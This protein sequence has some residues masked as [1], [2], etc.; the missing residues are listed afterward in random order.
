MKT[1]VTFLQFALFFKDIV[2]RPDRD[3]G[4]LNSEMLNIFDAMPQVIPVP[5]EL[6]PNIPVMLLRSEKNIY[7]CSISRSRI[8]FIVNRIDGIDGEKSNADILK[9]FNVKVAG[10]IKLILK[11]Q[12]VIRFGMVARYFQQ[13]NSAVKTLRNK[14]FTSIVGEA[15]E[16][17]L[18]YNKQSEAYGY[19]INDVLEISATEAVTDGKVE[20]G[21]LIQ[22]DINNHQI[23]GKKIGF[24]TLL[25][26]SEKYAP[27]ITEGEIEGL[28]K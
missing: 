6:S 25:K 20:K 10:I 26:I 19:Q 9:D 14:F 28:L 4:N 22:R 27:R 2:E 17:S 8:D 15:E 24:D 21:I 23:H 16:L 12:E 5:K 11:K 7:T 1:R 13:D 18:R 3:F